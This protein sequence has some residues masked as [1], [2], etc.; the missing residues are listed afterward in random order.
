MGQ[1]GGEARGAWVSAEVKQGAATILPRLS[2][3][4]LG[5]TLYNFNDIH[6]TFTNIIQPPG[7]FPPLLHS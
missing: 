7:A 6:N 4:L 2:L 1:C 3:Q 5:K